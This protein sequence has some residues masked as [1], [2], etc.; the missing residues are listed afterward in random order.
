M[1]GYPRPSASRPSAIERPVRAHYSI[2]PVT[3][4]TAGTY[5]DHEGIIGKHR[6]PT[7]EIKAHTQWEELY[8][9]TVAGMI[10]DAESNAL[11]SSGYSM[12]SNDDDLK[13]DV[14][15]MLA[16]SKV[17]Q[18]YRSATR[19]CYKHGYG[20]IE[21]AKTKGG[22]PYYVPISSVNMLPSYD[23]NGRIKEFH[24]YVGDT[25]YNAEPITLP[26]DKCIL[27]VLQPSLVDIGVSQISR[28]Q[29]AIQRHYDISK[30]SAEVIWR[31][32][33]PKW[34]ITLGNPDGSEAPA[35][36]PARIEG[37][38]SDLAPGSELTTN[39]LV[40]IETLD[41]QGIPQIESYGRWALSEVAVAMSCPRTI[42]GIQEG[43][44]ATAIESMRNYYNRL[45]SE[46]QTVQ[47]SIQEDIIDP[48]L[49]TKGYR[50]GDVNI[51]FNHPDPNRNIQV[52]QYVSTLMSM[53]PF[54]PYSIFTKEDY[55]D[56]LGKKLDTASKT[57][58][59]VDK[60]G[61]LIKN[62]VSK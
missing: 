18:A 32:G 22:L 31:H 40:N 19:E 55:A 27:L 9:K 37:V 36:I 21:K 51:I 15:A 4:I 50:P 43:A 41:S 12:R 25:A 10:V 26:L 30:A 3:T 49:M 39:P 13:T 6:N 53:D 38:T 46:A 8:A 35:D 47:S 23:D 56:I 58:D 62:G 20:V 54:D 2:A 29:E 17:E 57:D 16:Y 44:E 42:V 5:K 59:L 45:F 33:Y 34:D 28:A 52:A 61:E 11:F 7:E 24:Q 48:Y 60:I 14:E 1:H